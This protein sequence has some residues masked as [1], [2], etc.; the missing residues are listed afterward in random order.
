MA[1]KKKEVKVGKKKKEVKIVTN[2]FNSVNIFIVIIGIFVVVL[3]MMCFGNSL[4]QKI[5]GI[6]KN[7]TSTEI[8]FASCGITLVIYLGILLIHYLCMLIKKTKEVKKI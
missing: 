7:G 3:S 2:E 5:A 1:R 4:I 6:S 8:L